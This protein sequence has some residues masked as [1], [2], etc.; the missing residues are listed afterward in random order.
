M[1]LMRF[2]VVGVNLDRQ[3][4]ADQKRSFRAMYFALVPNERDTLTLATGEI[5]CAPTSYRA[6]LENANVRTAATIGIDEGKLEEEQKFLGVLTYLPEYKRDEGLQES[7][8]YLSLTLPRD[9]F[10]ELWTAALHST[11]PEGFT[12]EINVDYGWA[13]DGS[14]KKWDNKTADKVE[15]F[16]A[17]WNFSRPTQSK[18]DS[19]DDGEDNKPSGGFALFG[20]KRRQ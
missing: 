8:V 1:A 19:L 7:S 3:V 2:D 12:F 17:R 9:E 14:E 13:P 16:D 11:L 5:I 6:R 4:A 18:S 15:I 20:R 10:Q